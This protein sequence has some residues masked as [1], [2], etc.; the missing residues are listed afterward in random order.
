MCTR[1]MNGV[2]QFR[3][4]YSLNTRLPILLLLGL[5]LIPFVSESVFAQS[6][7]N[8]TQ[9]PPCFMNYTATGLELLQGCNYDGDFIEATTVG[10]EWVS[11]GLW[12]VIIVSVL[13]IM[14]YVKY[15]NGIYP[16]AIGIVFLP[17]AGNYFPDDFINMSIIIGAV[18]A[19][20]ALIGILMRNRQ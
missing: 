7:L 6:S 9:T 18:I 13:I 11:G 4:K 16:L 20:G 12:P 8:V 5:F 15:H 19:A 14:T 1:L 10:F 17:I 3:K 2:R